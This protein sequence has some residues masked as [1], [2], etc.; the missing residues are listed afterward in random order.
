MGPL[1]GDWFGQTVRNFA[2]AHASQPIGAMLF[3]G[4]LL[5]P[6]NRKLP[7]SAGPAAPLHRWAA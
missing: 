5:G 3:L 7:V 2:N 1:V 6:G 4:Y